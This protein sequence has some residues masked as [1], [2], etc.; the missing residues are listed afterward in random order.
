M[1]LKSYIYVAISVLVLL[2]LTFFVSRW[3][4]HCPPCPPV[5]ADTVFIKGDTVKVIENHYFTIHDTIKAEV[6]NDTARTNIPI[7]QTFG[8]DTLRGNTKIEYT[9]LDSIFR[10]DQYFEL[11][12][13]KEFR[14]DTVKIGIPINIFIEKEI[15][16][17][18]NPYFSYGL[19][20]LTAIIILLA[21]K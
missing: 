14:V 20:I 16:F 3:T 2:A 19:G 8:E 10:V 4:Y 11:V 17:Y 7:L 1:S 13:I 5:L 9:L 18:E 15:P 12:K 21:G 6:L